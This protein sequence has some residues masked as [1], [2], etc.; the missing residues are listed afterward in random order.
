MQQASN[1]QMDIVIELDQ[2]EVGALQQQIEAPQEVVKH[3]IL[4][5]ETSI[6]WPTTFWIRDNMIQTQTLA[7]LN[8]GGFPGEIER[9]HIFGRIFDECIKTT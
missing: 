3:E 4:G 5:S 9:S 2:K 7:F 6:A 8:S 1:R